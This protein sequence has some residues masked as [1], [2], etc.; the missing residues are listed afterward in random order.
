MG[1]TPRDTS[2]LLALFKS[3]PVATL[4]EIMA[5]LGTESRMTT[6]RVLRREG[7]HSSY[8]HRG[9]FYTLGRIV[10]FDSRGLW[11]YQ[12]VHFSRW[13]TLKRTAAHFVDSSCEGCYVNEL[14]EELGVETKE[15]LLAAVRSGQI[16]REQVAGRY[17]YCSANEEKR[18]SQVQA[19]T[20]PIV[21]VTADEGQDSPMNQVKAALVLFVST[22]SEK[23]RRLYAGLES[24]KL[25]R[26]GDT[27]IADLLDIDPH[28][29]ARG[30]REL[31]GGDVS[32]SRLRSPGGGRPAVEKKRQK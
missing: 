22:L 17:L 21:S 3:Q 6:F 28:T 7:G 10:E 20:R 29:V 27:L 24:M 14:N 13:G 2:G 12:E 8:S 30:R 9:S 11:S 18:S 25:G 19:R 4:A 5:A 32:V 26:G 31:L 15:S 16:S 1:R 23:Q